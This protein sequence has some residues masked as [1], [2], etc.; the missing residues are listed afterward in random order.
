MSSSWGNT[1]NFTDEPADMYGK[2]MSMSDTLVDDYFMLCTRV[3]VSEIEIMKEERE[4]SVLHPRDMKMRLAR[5]IVTMYH[6]AENAE[7]AE[8]NFTETLSKGGNPEN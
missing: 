7:L 3:S 4:S 2:V 8:K 1:I 6:G 5:E